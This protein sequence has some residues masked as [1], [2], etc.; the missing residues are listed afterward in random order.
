MFWWEPVF[1]L[2]DPADIFPSL[3]S[4]PLSPISISPL[5]LLCVSLRETSIFLLTKTPAFG[6]ESWFAF[7]CP[8][9][10]F[11]T[12]ELWDTPVSAFCFGEKLVLFLHEGY[13]VTFEIPDATFFLHY[14]R[15]HSSFSFFVWLSHKSIQISEKENDEIIAWQRS[16]FLGRGKGR[17]VKGWRGGIGVRP[18]PM[19]FSAFGFQRS[20]GC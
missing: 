6:G 19:S 1:V 17:G 7:M 8:C 9:K 4:A 13:S 12:P 15:S 3:Y 11:Y 20:P 16:L 2:D 14:T 5:T 10:I 18:V